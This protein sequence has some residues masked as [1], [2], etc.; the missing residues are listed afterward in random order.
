MKEFQNVP[1]VA[2]ALAKNAPRIAKLETATQ[3]PALLPFLTAAAA[4]GKY[5]GSKAPAGGLPPEL[6]ALAGKAKGRAAA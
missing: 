5:A 6:A 4:G 1:V 3:N 2:L